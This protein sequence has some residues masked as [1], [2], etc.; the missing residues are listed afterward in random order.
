[1]IIPDFQII[2]MDVYMYSYVAMCV[3]NHA[4]FAS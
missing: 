1:M 3:Q 4:G 2:R